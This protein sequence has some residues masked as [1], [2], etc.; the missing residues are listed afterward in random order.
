MEGRVKGEKEE[1]DS[2]EDGVEGRKRGEG[3]RWMN[4]R[5]NE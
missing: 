5:Q 3:K 4:G 2:R 1:E